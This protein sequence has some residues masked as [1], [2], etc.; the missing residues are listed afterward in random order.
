M[1]GAGMI[2]KQIY[3]TEEMNRKLYEIA[4][5]KGVPQ[6]EII[7]EGLETYLIA[8]RQKDTLWD[9]MI[10]QMK[11]SQFSHLKWSREEIYGERTSGEGNLVNHAS[12]NNIFKQRTPEEDTSREQMEETSI[13]ER[14]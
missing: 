4:A 9:E 10:H 5:S 11:K 13:H 1:E 7:R 8:Y 12:G 14:E 2:R 3:L 6:A